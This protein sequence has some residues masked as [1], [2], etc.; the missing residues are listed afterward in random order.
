MKTHLLKNTLRASAYS[1]TAPRQQIFALLQEH[2]PIST[3]QLV[4]KCQETID[5][6]TVYRTVELFESLGI[7]NRIWHGFKSTLE[8]SEIFMPHHHHAMCQLCGKTIDVTSQDLERAIGAVAKE[9]EFLP[10][11]HSV[12]LQGYCRDCQ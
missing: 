6:A 7:V 12:E 11:A 3:A 9:H 8:L 2:G 5:R 4:D 10:L 1:I